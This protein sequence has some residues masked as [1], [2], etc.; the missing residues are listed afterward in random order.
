MAT[1]PQQLT[2]TEGSG[3]NGGYQR[4][5]D[6][7]SFR[8][9]SSKLKRSDSIKAAKKAVKTGLQRRLPFLQWLPSY[10]WSEDLF[11]DV[12]GG[13]TIGMVC[14]AQTLAH[15]A[16]AT[17]HDIQGPYTAF[18]PTLVYAFLGTSC[19][20]SVSSGAIAAILIADQLRQWPNM[21]DR[22]ELASL[23]AFVAGVTLLVMGTCKMAFAVRF[24]SH[25]TLS[26]FITGGSML[27]ILQQTRNL[28]GFRHFPHTDGLFSHI[29]ATYAHLGDIEPISL[30]LGIILMVV[31]DGFNR[32][33]KYAALQVKKGGPEAKKY[34]IIKRFTEMKEIAVAAAGTLFGYLTADKD[35]VPLL[36]TVG[37]IPSGL[38]TYRAP[39]DV[40]AFQDLA[41]D[42]N[43]LANFL[44]GGVLVALC[45]FLTTYATTKKMALRFGYQLDASQEMIALGCA[46]ITGSFFQA[47][48]PSG[49]L[50]RTGLAA[51]CGVRTQMGGVAAAAVVGL[52]LMFLTPSLK[53]L[54]KAA[55]A[56]VIMKST[57]NLMDWDTPK[58]LMRY[59]RP[60]N[61]GGLKRDMV[62]WCVAFVFT[63]FLGVV[64]GIGLAVLISIVL[65]VADAAEPQ[66]VELGKVEAKHRR[67][68]NV[69]DWPDAETYPGILVFEFR[70]PLAFASAEF[71][72]EQIERRHFEKEKKDKTRLSFI[73][74]SF[75]SVHHLDSTALTTLEDLLIE[76]R[77]KSISC[78]IASAR[79]QVRNLIQE[80]FVQQR[81]EQKK[82]ALLD[83]V[84]LMISVSDAVDLAL[85]RQRGR[86]EHGGASTDDAVMKTVSSSKLP[87]KSAGPV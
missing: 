75:E 57:S 17:T 31:L 40:P 19:H 50:S 48:T 38:P 81:L 26:G 22:T 86:I 21:A 20:A 8:H 29:K 87:R 72:Q 34:R 30:T 64:Y 58:K 78:V 54:P 32:L 36:L 51:D 73:V 56:A 3:G 65:I 7:P 63:V 53:Y 44:T 84:D 2:H 67:Y 74:L 11:C 42:T 39:W 25:E 45:S 62:I 82:S 46:G 35:G 16:I 15:A 47:F 37:H 1:A 85:A 60:K 52:G 23:L 9:Q 41:S 66:A 49:S 83:Q 68:R 43:K 80:K 61:Q 55:L 59:W 28:F 71:F 13:T 69:D 33:K 6:K 79:H 5:E 14:L 10:N 76:W 77:E 18:M 12:M 70:G 24:L 27:I 4:L